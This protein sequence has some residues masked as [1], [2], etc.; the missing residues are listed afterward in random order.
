MHER[1]LGSLV[2]RI[3]RIKAGA[4]IFGISPEQPKRRLPCPPRL[5]VDLG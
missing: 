1:Q 4:G 2:M 3:A 5:D